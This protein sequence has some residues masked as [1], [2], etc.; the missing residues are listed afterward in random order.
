MR[1][2]R[3][4]RLDSSDLQVFDPAAA[5]GEPA[6]PGG[7]AFAGREPETLTGKERQA[8]ASGWLGTESFG[9]ASLVEVGE[10]SE[11]EFFQAIERLARH[12]VERYGAPDLA[13][14]LPAAR[15][16]V[17]YA[18]GL[19]EHKLHTLLAIERGWNEQGIAARFRVIVPSRNPDH[20]RIWEIV[21]DK[22]ETPEGRD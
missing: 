5:A 20:A 11:A 9:R 14:A 13:A 8:F 3:T 12:F 17:D 7:F 15:E 22:G 16:E 4:V 1:F 6:V 18:A 10:I 2:P 21:E 19:C